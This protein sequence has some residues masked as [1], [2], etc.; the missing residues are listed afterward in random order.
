MV[1]LSMA[2]PALSA[3]GR[4]VANDNIRVTTGTRTTACTRGT[5]A[6]CRISRAAA[7]VRVNQRRPQQRSGRGCPVGRSV[8]SVPVAAPGSFSTFAPAV[9]NTS[10]AVP[11][12]RQ[13][14]LSRGTISGVQRCQ[15]LEPWEFLPVGG[16]V[17]RMRSLPS[18]D[19]LRPC[20][21][22]CYGDSNTAGYNNQGR[23]YNPYAESLVEA[24]NIGGARC[25]VGICGL[26]GYTAQEFVAYL[27]EPFFE[28]GAGNV[29][30]GLRRI[31]EEDGPIDLVII[32][33][34]T[35]D[36][37]RG[38]HPVGIAKDVA[39]LHAAC[40]NLGVPSVA[41]APPGSLTRGDA[42]RLRDL[43]RN[44]VD[45]LPSY[46]E[47]TDGLL[48]YFDAEELVPRGP[49]GYWEPDEIHL[50]PAGSQRL[51]RRL[52]E[53]LL[54]VLKA[55]KLETGVQCDQGDTDIFESAL[56]RSGSAAV[57][58]AQDGSA[59]RRA[60]TASPHPAPSSL[61]SRRA[62]TTSPNRA[63][64][65]SRKAMQQVNVPAATPAPSFRAHTSS[66]DRAASPH[67]AAPLDGADSPPPF[68]RSGAVPAC[69]PAH[70]CSPERGTSPQV[71]VMT[72][73][74]VVLPVPRLAVSPRLEL[75]RANFTSAV[76]A[77]ATLPW[78]PKPKETLRDISMFQDQRVP[79]PT[80]AV[81]TTF[82]VLR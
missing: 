12:C 66:P 51:G 52:F 54:P 16:S 68:F 50:S 21:I 72:A 45:L 24:L 9:R 14:V 19:R 82:T 43:R 26:N 6:R 10:L 63:V 69:R 73:G 75:G 38:L 29:G 49:G 71:T 36:L 18:N 42:V 79:Y 13:Q 8:V 60:R 34:G 3:H 44:V 57:P 67:V 56:I 27:D 53:W 20:R 31:I 17:R 28:D 25:E 40:H 62:Q 11:I 77:R 81:K 1:Y 30:K 37:G 32:M 39:D 80:I 55:A 35:N 33:L 7:A 78:T 2:V 5:A 64:S 4:G 58:P 65:P 23:S 48:A 74:A 70:P 76:N 41:L 47:G 61:S 59:S 46:L 22:L 15:N